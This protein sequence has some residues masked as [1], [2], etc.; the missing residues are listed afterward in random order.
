MNT[1]KIYHIPI[2]LSLYIYI[3][4][5]SFSQFRHPKSQKIPSKPLSF[6][7]VPRKEKKIRETFTQTVGKKLFRFDWAANLVNL[8]HPSEGRRKGGHRRRVPDGGRGGPTL[9]S[10]SSNSVGDSAPSPSTAIHQPPRVACV[11]AA[12]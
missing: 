6:R 10:E 9:N 5:R 8:Q 4:I 3:H 12:A 1:I 7:L 2:S 11:R